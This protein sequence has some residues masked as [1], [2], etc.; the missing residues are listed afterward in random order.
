MINLE[1]EHRP[2]DGMAQVVVA[3]IPRQVGEKMLDSVVDVLLGRDPL[4][5]PIEKRLAVLLSAIF[6][7][8]SSGEQ[9]VRRQEVERIRRCG[10]PTAVLVDLSWHVGLYSQDHSH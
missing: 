9:R 7:H 1:G 3:L 2:Q 10:L 4:V 8:L 6:C 5:I